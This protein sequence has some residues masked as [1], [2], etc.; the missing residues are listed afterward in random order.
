MFSVL[1]LTWHPVAR[2]LELPHHDGLF[3]STV[4]PKA[5]T[6][7]LEWL[8]P[9][10]SFWLQESN[11]VASEPGYSRVFP[12]AR[13]LKVILWDTVAAS[14]GQPPSDRQPQSRLRTCLGNRMGGLGS[15]PA[16]GVLGR[17]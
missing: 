3:P 5:N 11:R 2:C 8:L 12:R 13:G 15:R 4:T 7:S 10:I 1:C 14:L 9:P 16:G 17:I 6:F